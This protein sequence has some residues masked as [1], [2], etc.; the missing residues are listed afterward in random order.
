MSD[1]L[2]PIEQG[3]CAIYDAAIEMSPDNSDVADLA[4]RAFEVALVA[5]LGADGPPPVDPSA[6]TKS[7]KE[8]LSILAVYPIDIEI[9]PLGGYR[10]LMQALDGA[11]SG[12]LVAVTVGCVPLAFA[13]AV[14]V[15]AVA[16][17]SIVRAQDRARI[18]AEISER[19]RTG[20]LEATA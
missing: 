16:A 1:L 12:R 10:D 19:I 3:V 20:G 9:D 14:I 11:V 4:V 18:A 2:S 7:F 17:H 5:E 6:L 13:R 15:G 8:A